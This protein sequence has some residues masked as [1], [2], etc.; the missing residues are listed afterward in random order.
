MR[1][2]HQPEIEIILTHDNE[3]EGCRAATNKDEPGQLPTATRA[4]EGDHPE[5]RRGCQCY[6]EGPRVAWK[7]YVLHVPERDLEVRRDQPERRE[8]VRQR[9]NAGRAQPDK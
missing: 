7:R 6:P 5:C 2:T 8:P 1:L 9:R 4:A 3:R